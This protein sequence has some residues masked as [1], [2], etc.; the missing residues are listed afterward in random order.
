MTMQGGLGRG[1][2]ASH[3]SGQP[4]QRTSSSL[5]VALRNR[6]EPL[7]NGALLGEASSQQCGDE[8]PILLTK[9]AQLCD[10]EVVSFEAPARELGLA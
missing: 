2:V 5:T 6:R 8:V 4:L 9:R 1:P 7:R 10:A 3:P